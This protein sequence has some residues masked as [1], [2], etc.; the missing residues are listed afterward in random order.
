MKMLNKYRI[1]Y[2]RGG[3]KAEVDKRTFENYATGKISAEEG[4]YLIEKNNGCKVTVVQFIENAR[5]LGY[6]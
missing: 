3:H 1:I 2:A 6:I 4:A 5:W